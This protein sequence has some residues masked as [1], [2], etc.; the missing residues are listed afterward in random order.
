MLILPKK[1]GKDDTWWDPV[2]GAGLHVDD[3]AAVPPLKNRVSAEH[4]ADANGPLAESSSVPPRAAAEPDKLPLSQEGWDYL[5]DLKWVNDQFDQGCLATFAGNYIG[6][7]HRQL[8]GFGP[9]LPALRER[10]SREHGISPDRI[11]TSYVELPME[12]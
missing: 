11:L 8:L 2:I 3:E 6:V 7:Y 10:L 1:I 9:D 12:C 5:A 4:P